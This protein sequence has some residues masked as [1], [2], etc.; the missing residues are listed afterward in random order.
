M[1]NRSMDPSGIPGER[2]RLSGSE[3]MKYTHELRALNHG[4]LVGVNTV[5]LAD[6][7]SLTVRLCPGNNPKPVIL[8]SNLKPTTCKLLVNEQCKTN[9][10]VQLP[11]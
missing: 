7:P 11:K 4:I 1:H 9:Y 8:D 6:D 3:S 5:V 10:F 2:L